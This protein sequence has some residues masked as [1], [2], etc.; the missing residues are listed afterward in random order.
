MERTLL[1]HNLNW[2]VKQNA[3]NILQKT[4]KQKDPHNSKN[5]ILWKN[6]LEQQIAEEATSTIYGCASKTSQQRK[7]ERQL[8]VHRLEER[9]G[10]SQDFVVPLQLFCIESISTLFYSAAN[11][12]PHRVWRFAGNRSTTVVPA[13]CELACFKSST[14]SNKTPKLLLCPQCRKTHV[15]WKNCFVVWENQPETNKSLQRRRE[16]ESF[17]GDN[18]SGMCGGSR[19]TGETL[20][21]SI[22]TCCVLCTCTF[23]SCQGTPLYNFALVPS[24]QGTPINHEVTPGPSL[25]R[26]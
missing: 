18:S 17:F 25:P 12:N 16:K 14:N 21:T 9:L 15:M 8:H 20:L 4:N 13:W 2:L 7:P 11:Q 22:R 10:R 23:L 19:K 1:Q 24:R 26:R 3:D 6:Q 5:C